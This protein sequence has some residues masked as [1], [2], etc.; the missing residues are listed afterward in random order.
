MAV[1]L[2]AGEGALPEEIAMRLARVGEHPVV[3][4]MRE[5]CE[6]FSDYAADIVPVFKTELAASLADMASRGVRKVM[7]AGLVPKTLMY[8]PEMLDKMAR[9]LVDDLENRDDH[10]L[11]GSIVAI[12]ERAG[13]SV[14]GYTDIL[15]DLIAQPGFV[16]GRCPTD[17]ETADVR[18]GIE[19]ARTVAPLSFGQSIVVNRRSV[20]AVEAMEGT[21]ATILRAGALCR[22]GVL[23][24]MIKQG[25]DPRFDIPVVGPNT[26][27]LMNKAGLTCLAVRAGW[28]LVISPDEFAAVA[29]EYNLSVTGIDY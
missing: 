4:A 3:Y 9:K 29:R 24:K 23:V 7:F 5:D 19:I 13:F 11:L 18:Y 25:Q 16:A 26:L 22:K 12:F 8:R 17:D 20:V 14:V 15:S 2:I 21:D 10:T 27:N 28:T 6:A 1:A